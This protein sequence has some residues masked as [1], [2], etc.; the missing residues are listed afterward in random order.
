MKG[1]VIATVLLVIWLI[2]FTLQEDGFNLLVTNTA[3]LEVNFNMPFLSTSKWGGYIE[4]NYEGYSNRH[5]FGAGET[6]YKAYFT[7]IELKENNRAR[8]TAAIKNGFGFSSNI[9]TEYIYLNKG[10]N[11]TTLWLEE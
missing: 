2:N 3:D 9:K 11:K 8:I 6:N 7:G 1:K 5:E 10:D 4:I